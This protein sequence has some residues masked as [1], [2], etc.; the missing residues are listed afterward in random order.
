VNFPHTFVKICG[1][2]RLRDA[3]IAT[4]AG[5][6]ALG[7]V[8]DKSP[9]RIAPSAARKIISRVHPSVRKIGVFVDSPLQRILDVISRSGIDGVQLQGDEPQEFIDELRSRDPS[10]FIAKV[11]KVENEEAVKALYPYKA[12]AIFLDTK[13]PKA[14]SE[15]SKA[16]PTAWL[17]GLD[18]P[19]VLAGGLDPASVR[20]AVSSLRPWGVDVSRGVES[21]PGKKDRDLVLAFIRAVREGEVMARHPSVA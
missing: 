17:Q 9:R 1:I 18:L 15:T 2:T 7:F 16:I 6:D 19:Y 12:D 8:F 4:R 10:L 5:A 20:K 13:D 21:A 11:L 14:L 3:R